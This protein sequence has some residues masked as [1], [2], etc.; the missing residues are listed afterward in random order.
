M[1]IIGVIKVKRFEQYPLLPS[2]AMTFLGK[3]RLLTFPAKR[4]DKIGGTEPWST[5]IFP[6]TP[7]L[8]ADPIF[9]EIGKLDTVV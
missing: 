7:I 6:F 1:Y 4:Y 2:K 9:N 5:D 8:P 3:I